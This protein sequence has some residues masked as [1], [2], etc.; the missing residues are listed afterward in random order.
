MSEKELAIFLVQS[1]IYNLIKV[2]EIG[3]KIVDFK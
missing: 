3:T 2:K 1:F